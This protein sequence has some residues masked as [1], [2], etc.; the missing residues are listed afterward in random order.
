M[1]YLAVRRP[2]VLPRDFGAGVQRQTELLAL[3][4][5]RGVLVAFLRVGPTGGVDLGRRIDEQEIVRDVLVTGCALLRQVV[6]PS[7]RLQD[8]ADQLLLGSGFVGLLVAAELPVARAEG[9]PEGGK[10]GV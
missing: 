10:R 5:H 2:A 9:V 7:Q 4:D 3:F 6:S 1:Q 8:R